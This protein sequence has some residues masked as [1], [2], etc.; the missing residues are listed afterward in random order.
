MTNITVA[1]R[2]KPSNQGEIGTVLFKPNN[3]VQLMEH[4]SSPLEK[5][6]LFDYVW[7]GGE[8]AD[9][10]NYIESNIVDS[11]MS[12]YNTTLFTYGQTAS[13]KTFTIQGPADKCAYNEQT[14]GVI[15]RILPTLFDKI[16]QLNLQSP[17]LKLSYFE[18]YNEEIYD[19][20]SSSSKVKYMV[21]KKEIK[22]FGLKKEQ[23]MSAEQAIGLYF[24]AISNR[25]NASTACNKHSSRSHS[26]LL[27]TLDCSII[28]NNNVC[29]F[30]SSMHIIELAGSE[31][32]EK[33]GNTKEKL[34]EGN[35]INL[36]LSALGLVISQL[37]EGKSYISFR[38]SLLASVIIK[39]L[40]GES[41]TVAIINVSSSP[42][43]FGETKAS[44]LFSQK[45]RLIK[46]N[47]KPN[48]MMHNQSKVQPILDAMKSDN[49]IKTLEVSSMHIMP[50][51]QQHAEDKGSLEKIMPDEKQQQNSKDDNSTII[52]LT[53]LKSK[54]KKQYRIQ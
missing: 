19:L 29:N 21:L 24:G 18:I 54:G 15:P 35:S 38:N 10:Y 20:L 40:G 53:P 22:Y 5:E 46:K 11:F 34:I 41:K 8:Q 16:N 4:P 43:S 6:Y 26:V 31:R 49:T 13:G 32:V 42:T 45:I 48:A 7:Q 52:K 51:S 50:S 12:G 47:P 39:S 1:L 27:I 33:T 23:I 36:S 3:I 9:I 28:K 44:L 37:S 17:V 30:K 25:H 14:K 2:V